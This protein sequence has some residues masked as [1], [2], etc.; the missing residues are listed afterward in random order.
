ML[1]YFSNS[2]VVYNV[3]VKVDPQIHEEWFEWMKTVHIPNVLTT[4]MFTKCRLS[5]LDVQEQDGETYVFQY[6]CFSQEKL[7]QYMIH[8]APALQKEVIEKYANRF[9]AFRTVLNVLEEQ[10]A[11][12]QQS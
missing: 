10:Y 7:N 12:Q 1:I 11:R 8:H 5:K 4:G 3:T 9:V 6:D 2:M